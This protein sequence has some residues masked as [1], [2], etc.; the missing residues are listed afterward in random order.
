[1]DPVTALTV[2]GTC[3]AVLAVIVAVFQLRRTPPLPESAPSPARLEEGS[4]PTAGKPEDQPASSALLA[5]R[6]P[7]GRLGGIRGRGDV[8]ATL[9]NALEAP[10]GRFHVL[11]GLGGTGK[12]TAALALADHA[13]GRGRDVWWVNASHAAAVTGS[14]LGLALELGASIGQVEE[15]RAG[16]RDP[17]DLLWSR[18]EERRGWLLVLDNADD[19]SALT[20][21]G[22]EARDGTG[23][24]RPTMAG[25]IVVT[26][27]VSDPSAW[28]R[29]G[30]LHTMRPLHAPDGGRALLDL[31]PDGGSEQEAAALSGRLGGLP[32]ALAHAGAHIASPFTEERTFVTYLRALDDRFPSLMGE[33][34]V[35]DTWEVSLDALAAH[36]HGQA[37]PL[38][39]TLSCFAPSMEIH[40]ALLDPA[41]LGRVCED[42]RRVRPGLEALASM[43]LIDT[44]PV[45]GHVRP[46]VVVH[47]IVAAACRLR[48]TTGITSV[49]AAAMEAVTEH[50]RHDEPAHWPV[51]ASLLP[52]V[53]EL[54]GLAPAIVDDNAL[55]AIARSA[56]R[57]C[58]A[59]K[60]SGEYGGAMEI[61]AAALRQAEGLGGDH[62]AVLDLR[63]A[64]GAV[65]SCMGHSVEAERELR[66]THKLRSRVLGADHPDTLAAQHETAH[67]LI[68]RGRYLDAMH[69]YQRVLKRRERVLGKDHP[70]TTTT[71]HE[72]ARMLGNLGRFT[73]SEIACREVF[74]AR[75]RTLGPDHPET[76]DSR[77]YWLR[78]VGEQGRY[79]EAERAF[80]EL[81]E[82]RT[83][84]LGA[85]HPQ[86]LK[87]RFNLTWQIAARGRH[88]EAEAGYQ[89]VADVQA[90]VLGRDHPDTLLTEVNLGFVI[91]VRGR[92]A[93][94]KTLFRK[95]IAAWERVGQPE[96][97][98]AWD[99]RWGLVLVEARLEGHAHAVP[100]LR[101]VVETLKRTH[102]PDHPDVLE[103]RLD[104]ARFLSEVDHRSDAARE[105]DDLLVAARRV[106]GA[107][108]PLT[109]A[110]ETE[111]ATVRE[112]GRGDGPPGSVSA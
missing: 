101:N 62:R 6:V 24:L 53:A 60:R 56:A 3:A 79:E 38:L 14:L 29:H 54:V 10:D 63:Y 18:L 32:L 95:I 59:L 28:G 72:V 46:G 67:A 58:R 90:R 109:R 78:A 49:A 45:P 13:Q 40:P 16:R 11:T 87:A 20:V 103:A 57:L 85:E 52:H 111:L 5:F 105:L 22:A 47:P 74:E 112:G 15:A 75:L 39:R 81:V 94:A 44:A 77:Y 17:A 107:G 110:V 100:A 26:S 86:T 108:H 64:L 102:G 12:T 33:S 30:V 71:R 96:H 43:N 1:M 19:L 25:S 37:R 92:L 41:V 66:E 104:L 8:I 4:E 65:L 73:E 89:D 99:A 9:V 68:G 21:A 98:W 69:L 48:L 27:R 83:R 42:R 34:P 61:A 106:R 80:R 70:A 31:V 51:W 23:W 91:T 2:V 55:A 50:L 93:E 97:Q 82:D 88:E 84:V 76:L 7:T 35:V 36:G